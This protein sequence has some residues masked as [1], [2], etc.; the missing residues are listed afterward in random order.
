M[1][2]VK[3]LLRAEA[4]GTISFG[5]YTL[6]QKAKLPDFEHKGDI[7][8]VKTYG[9]STRLE[10]NGMFVYE[11]VRGTSVTEFSAREDCVTFQVE[12]SQ[13]AQITLELAEETEYMIY[14]DEKATG[15]MTTNRSGKLSF[16]VELG[17]APVSIRIQK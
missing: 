16:S 5:D 1:S 6:S 12:G 8:Y 3:E 2:V 15:K 9:E 17:G 4:D 13:D 7:Y 10:Q 14:V 11:S